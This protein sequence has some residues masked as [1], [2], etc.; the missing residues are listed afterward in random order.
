MSDLFETGPDAPF[1]ASRSIPHPGDGNRRA[2]ARG[3]LIGMHAHV[4]LA[5]GYG[6][7][8]GAELLTDTLTAVRRE[9]GGGPLSVEDEAG[10]AAFKRLG[11]EAWAKPHRGGS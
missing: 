7:I 4:R 6:F 10:I 1:I 5:P 8:Y 9:R 11:R 2:V 3:S